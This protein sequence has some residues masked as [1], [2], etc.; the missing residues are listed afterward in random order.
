MSKVGWTVCSKC[1]VDFWR[2]VFVPFFPLFRETAPPLPHHRTRRSARQPGGFCVGLHPGR[3]W[4]DRGDGAAHG[5][6][7]GHRGIAVCGAGPHRG[8]ARQPAARHAV[9]RPGHHPG[10]AGRAAGGEYWCGGAANHGETP[11]AGREPAHAPALELPPPAAGPEHGLLPGRVCRAYH[12]QGDADRTGRARHRV[13]AGRR[14]GH[15]GGV[16]RH[17]GGSGRR[18]G[19]AADVALPGLAGALH[20][21]AGV[22]CAPAGPRG[23]GPGRR[24]CADDGPGDRRVHQHRHRQA[25]LTQPPRGRFCARRDAGLHGHG[26]RPDAA[27]ECVRDR[28]PHA[29]HGTHSGYGGYVAVAVVAGD[30]WYWRG[31]RIHR[32]GAAPARHVALDHVGDDQPVREHRHGAG[33]HENA[34]APARRAGRAE[35]TGTQRAAW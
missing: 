25:V 6:H 35:R 32:H 33:R 30:D 11:D 2:F 8:L 9:A 10:L 31:G 7:V 1:C 26:P 17:H 5:R 3:A 14:G 27:G 15:D 13:C 4:Q 19:A 16:C 28:Q 23:Q 29:E 18:A 34:V 21:R 12:R 20:R 22:F 24:P